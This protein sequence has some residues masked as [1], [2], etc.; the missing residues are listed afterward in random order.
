MSESS[1]FPKD[2][3]VETTELFFSGNDSAIFTTLVTIVTLLASDIPNAGVF[4][5]C[6]LD[7]FVV[8]FPYFYVK[9]DGVLFDF[10]TSSDFI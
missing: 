2:R 7:E 5:E 9:D 3:T 1:I 6:V 10:C 4:V 8:K